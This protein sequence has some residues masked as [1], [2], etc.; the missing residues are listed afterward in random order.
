MVQLIAS[1]FGLFSMEDKPQFLIQENL[2]I[3]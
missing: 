3:L 2:M 1:Y